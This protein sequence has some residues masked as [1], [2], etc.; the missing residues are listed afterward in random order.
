MAYDIFKRVQ[1]GRDW[2][3]GCGT[4]IRRASSSGLDVLTTF[5]D[6]ALLAALKNWHNAQHKSSS[7]GMHGWTSGWT[8]EGYIGSTE[9][10]RR[11]KR[12]PYYFPAFA[13]SGFK[14]IPHSAFRAAVMRTAFKMSPLPKTKHLA[15]ANAIVR[16]QMN[17]RGFKLAIP[18]ARPARRTV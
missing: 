15:A 6:Q 18:G 16:R 3:I 12:P 8:S 14:L 13:V 11:G 10:S 2:S 7:S 4:P 5:A 9:A 17:A 1:T